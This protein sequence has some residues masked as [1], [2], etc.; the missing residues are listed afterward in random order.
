MYSRLIIMLIGIVITIAWMPGFCQEMQAKFALKGTLRG[1]EDGVTIYLILDGDTV[2]T[3]KGKS[4]KFELFGEVQ[5]GANFYFL[6]LDTNITKTSS[7]ALWLENA[8]MEI[9]GDVGKMQELQLEGSQ[10]QYQYI[11]ALEIMKKSDGRNFSQILE[12][13]DT[14]TSLYIPHLL[15]R[16]S[17]LYKI[18]DLEA[19]Y[20]KL[21][22]FAKQ[23]YYGKQLKSEIDMRS[24]YSE[25]YEKG[26]IGN[27]LPNFKVKLVDGKVQDIHSILLKN[28]VTLI[29]FWASWC[30]PCRAY[31]PTLKILYDKYH[32]DG[33]EILG[34]SIDK[35]EKNWKD[36]INED[37][38]M[39]IH[40]QD[41]NESSNNVFKM[42]AIPGYI[43]INKDLRV[44]YA[45]YVSSTTMSNVTQNDKK[46]AEKLSELMSKYSK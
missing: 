39:W 14:A 23:T 9:R 15:L 7:K 35:I 3:T 44:V 34:I 37:K 46:V 2:G 38:T 32:N 30:A 6:K 41:I 26:P 22:A 42:A 36:A 25:F 13:A 24:K 29:D 11:Q 16:L 33:F 12:F 43:L 10:S 31:T 19:V 20:N 5:G 4:G 1:L 8:E 28:R 18:S 45:D 40:C 27:V 17:G 21:S